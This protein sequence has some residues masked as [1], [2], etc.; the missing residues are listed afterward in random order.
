MKA[1][2]LYEEAK[3]S[4]AQHLGLNAYYEVVFTYNATYAFNL[5]SRSLIKTGKLKK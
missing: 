2:Q 3:E 4:I 5:V 1:S